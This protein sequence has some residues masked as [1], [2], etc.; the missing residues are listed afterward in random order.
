MSPILILIVTVAYFTLLYF[1]S[2]VTGKDNSND[3]FFAGNKESPWYLV[4]YGM[5]GATLS[6]ITFISVPG[7]VAGSKFSYMQVILGNVVGFAII[8]LV[9]LPLYYKLNLTSIYGYL[10]KRFGNY[11][12][13]TGASCFLISRIIGASLRLYLV[14]E[15][16]QRFLFGQWGVPYWL[17]VVI[18]IG[19]IWLYTFRGGIKTIVYTDTLQT[20]FIL[21]SVFLTVYYILAELPTGFVET[22]VDSGYSQIFF[23]ENGWSDSNNFFKKFLSGVF[24]AI[25]MIGLDQD[26]M[27]K[28]LTVKT[29]KDSQKNMMVT[30]SVLLV[31]NLVFL[32]L[33]ALL[34]VSANMKGIEIPTKMIDGV[35]KP[36]S[37]LLFPEMAINHLPLVVGVFFIIGLLAAAYSSADSALTSLTTSFCVDFL[38]FDKEDTRHD[39][40]YKVHFMFSVILVLVIIAFHYYN[41]ESA[42]WTLFRLAGYTYG[43][44]LGL[45][46]FGLIMKSRTVVDQA[47]PVICMLAPLLTFFIN[48]NSEVWLN[49]YKFGFEL[50]MLNG[51][52]TFLGL[53]VISK[54][55]PKLI[56]S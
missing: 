43:P 14:A 33:G 56:N 8:A 46:S 28:N 11:A 35:A 40:R 31:V 10:Q 36:A 4:A 32:C 39:L 25:V 9:L 2:S 54:K 49:G 20:T 23:F 1:I 44:L 30:A 41:D 55:T 53:L 24:L 52:I 6:G 27:Q 5:V 38:G 26:M 18:A 45:F 21:L 15:V 22:V 19:L 48:K 47:V 29:M 13:R 51:L 17:T 16:L 3:A 42:V 7:W 34:F 50:L 12:Y 37:D